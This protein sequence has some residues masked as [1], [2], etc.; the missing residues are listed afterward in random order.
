MNTQNTQ[1]KSSRKK[2]NTQTKALLEYLREH[3]GVTPY[4]AW[5]QLHIYRL[6]D[7]IYK[8]RKLGYKIVTNYMEVVTPYGKAYIAEYRMIGEAE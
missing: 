4:E 1:K 5:N 8:L 7:T 2:E 3:G 6:S